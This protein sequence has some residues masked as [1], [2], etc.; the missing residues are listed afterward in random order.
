MSASKQLEDFD[1]VEDDYEN[2]YYGEEYEDEELSKYFVKAEISETEKKD[3]VNFIKIA[4]NQK[5]EEEK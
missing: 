1:D 4:Q 3:G 2:D 5:E